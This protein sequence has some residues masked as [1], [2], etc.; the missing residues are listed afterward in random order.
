MKILFAVMVFSFGQWASATESYSGT[1][2]LNY[3]PV[4]KGPEVVKVTA[5]Y[6]AIGGNVPGYTLAL[7]GIV[8]GTLWRNGSVLKGYSRNSNEY[9]T[10][11]LYLKPTRELLEKANCQAQSLSAE[12]IERRGVLKALKY[13][14]RSVD[15]FC[16][17]FG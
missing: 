10:F 16:V 17:R 11:S 4:F 3:S 14:E 12:E 2:T 1:Y 5:T 8:A 6:G 15:L 7:N 13:D 9:L